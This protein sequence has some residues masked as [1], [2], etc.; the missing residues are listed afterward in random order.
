MYFASRAHAGRLLADQIGAVYGDKPCSILSLS[1]GGV[2]VGMQIAQRLH[3]PVGML[4]VNE[5]E[6]PRELVAIAGIT[7]DGSF[8]YNKHFSPGEIEEMVS[9]Y[10]GIIEASKIEKLQEMHRAL[11]GGGLVRRD[12]LANRNIIIV[13]DGFT[14]GFSIDL[15]LEYLKP[16][17]YPKLIIATPQASVSAVDRMHIIADDL[18]CLNVVEE[19]INTD[20]YYDT[21]DVPAHEVVTQTVAY[22]MQQW[23]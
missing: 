4:L 11:S 12:L 15:A 6:L 8:S 19:Y 20:H 16:I 23:G 3:C 21:Q 18:Y 9:E 5:I 14:S 7:Q 17:P 2:V 10:R 22:M 1:D 13:S